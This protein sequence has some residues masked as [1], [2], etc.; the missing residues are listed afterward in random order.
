MWDYKDMQG[1]HS[2]II[3]HNI[4]II[5]SIKP[6]WK[7]QCTIHLHLSLVIKREVEKLLG[8]RFIESI[9]YSQ[10]VSNIVLMA[11]KNGTI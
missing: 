3:E 7:K 8:A 5:P 10:W 1:I 2:Q 11:K 9:D 4:T 6:K